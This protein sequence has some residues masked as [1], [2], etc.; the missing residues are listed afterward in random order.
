MMIRPE[1]RHKIA[2][3]QVVVDAFDPSLLVSAPVM[4]VVDFSETTEEDLYDIE[5][6]LVFTIGAF[7]LRRG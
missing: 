5:I 6:P 4:K 2:F 1:L 7:C 3:W